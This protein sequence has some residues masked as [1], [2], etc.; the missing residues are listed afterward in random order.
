[1]LLLATRLHV[2]LPKA[3][4]KTLVNDRFIALHMMMARI[5]P[6]INQARGSDEKLAAGTAHPRGGQALSDSE[7][8]SPSA[9]MAP[10]SG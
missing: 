8:R 10:R 6:T 9:C 7:S 4:N 1:L 2:D 3:P 5:D